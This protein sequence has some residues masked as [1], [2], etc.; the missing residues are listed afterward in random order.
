MHNSNLPP[1][2]Q[3]PCSK[4]RQTTIAIVLYY[5]EEKLDSVRFFMV[6]WLLDCDAKVRW[7]V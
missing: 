5:E 3:F 2:R 6:G 7:C 1:Y 4:N